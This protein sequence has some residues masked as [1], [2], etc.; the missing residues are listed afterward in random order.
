MRTRTAWPVI[1]TTFVCALALVFGC[2]QGESSTPSPQASA[3]TAPRAAVTPPSPPPAPTPAEATAPA[4]TPKSAEA[5]LAPTQGNQAHGTVTFT[6]AE[7]GVR[8]VV[9]VEGLEMGAHGFHVHEKGDCSAPDA[10]SAGGHFAPHGSPHGAPDAEPS[11]RHVGDLGNLEADASG[12]ADADRIDSM[13]WRYI[14]IP[15]TRLTLTIAT[16]QI[17]RSNRYF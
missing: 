4:A 6:P 11:H 7:G 9:H 2:N 8:V 14:G 17:L 16:Q 12:K 1:P 3:P 5:K 15:S 10:S 13:I